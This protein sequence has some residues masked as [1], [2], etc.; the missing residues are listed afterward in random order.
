MSN[1]STF[2]LDNLRISLKDLLLLLLMLL[3]LVD[4]N[5]GFL[6]NIFIN[7]NYLLLLLWRVVDWSF[8]LLWRVV[9]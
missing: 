1:F 8:R 3:W 2:I 5:L 6:R 4:C 7:L 9:D